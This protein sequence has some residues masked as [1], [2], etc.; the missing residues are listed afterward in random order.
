M[1]GILEPWFLVWFRFHIR[2][3]ARLLAQLI[4]QETQQH[5]TSQIWIFLWQTLFRYDVWAQSADSSTLNTQRPQRHTDMI[6]KRLICQILQECN[7]LHRL[8]CVSFSVF[9]YCP[10][11]TAHLSF[12]WPNTAA[13]KH[14]GCFNKSDWHPPPSPDPP[15]AGK[16]GPSQ[17]T[18]C[19]PLTTCLTCCPLVGVSASLT[20]SHFMLSTGLS[21]V[22][23]NIDFSWTVFFTWLSLPQ[24]GFDNHPA[25]SWM[26][27]PNLAA[28]QEVLE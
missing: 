4:I 18:S 20:S 15:V 10:T 3:C 12:I 23:N 19:T 25:F 26:L 1:N 5:Q 7:T 8:H 11:G 16:P 6:N 21:L 22:N 9:N 2:L 27:R 28:W 13:A 24:K 17:V 14:V